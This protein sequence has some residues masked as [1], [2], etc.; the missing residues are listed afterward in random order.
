MQINKQLLEELILEVLEE[1]GELD[2]WSLPGAKPGRLANI[3]RR[4][5]GRAGGRVGPDAPWGAP[6]SKS[7]PSG[8]GPGKE[9]GEPIGMAAAGELT[10][11][12]ALK[13]QLKA[14][15]VQQAL[16][17]MKEI[18]GKQPPMN[19]AEFLAG[20]MLEMGIDE[21]D[22]QRIASSARTKTRERAKKSAEMAASMPGGERRS[23]VQRSQSAPAGPS[24][25]TALSQGRK[26]GSSWGAGA[27]GQRGKAAAQE[28]K[29]RRV[30][31]EGK[32]RR[33]I[34]IRRKK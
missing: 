11:G 9:L 30:A 19:R 24:G 4:M 21:S 20:L 10:G 29:R 15:R 7:D 31:Q 16:V 6:P 28:G 3:A 12:A 17:V 14:P 26:L 23:P 5:S 22:V 2:E 34:R 33:V 27:A 13:L 18:I 8:V 1:E 25:V 32:K